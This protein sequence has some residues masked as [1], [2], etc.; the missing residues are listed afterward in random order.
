MGYSPW[1]QKESGT[2]ERLSTLPGQWHVDSTLAV[3]I[4]WGVSGGLQQC[5]CKMSTKVKR[6][7]TPMEGDTLEEYL[8]PGKGMKRNSNQN[9]HGMGGLCRVSPIHSPKT[10]ESDLR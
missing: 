3:G 5:N 9:S 2:T 6:V 10:D 7:R 4:V 1:G 8:W